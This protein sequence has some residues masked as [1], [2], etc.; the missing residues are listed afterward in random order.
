MGIIFA[1][2][3][4]IINL[5]GEKWLT[6]AVYLKIIMIGGIFMPFQLLNLKIIL[7]KK[8]SN[9]FLKIEI[10]K[11]ILIVINVLVGIR[12]GI[13][14]LLWGSSLI[15]LLSFFINNYY[16]HKL[17]GYGFRKQLL[18]T[19]Y[20][21]VSGG[22]IGTTIWL[23]SFLEYNKLIVFMTQISASIF[24]FFLL[25]EISRAKEY[26]V[27]KKYIRNYLSI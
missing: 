18:D 19:I 25:L 8:K 6:S 16:V 9:L 22:I 20:S 26:L 23:I 21:F 13:L 15:S 3:N 27:I 11:K 4:I 12:F 7:V 2:E 17:I 5:L 1:A 14:A 10:I 24:I